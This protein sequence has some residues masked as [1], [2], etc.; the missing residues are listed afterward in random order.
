MS[1]DLLPMETLERLSRQEGVD[2]RPILVRVLTD[3]FIQKETHA[4]EDVARYEE[5]MLQL[6]DVVGVDARAAV[7]RRLADEPRAPRSV[8]D[9]LVVDDIA[10]SAPVLARSAVVPRDALLAIALDGGVAEAGA[11]AN[12]A[13]VNEDLVRIL[14]FHADD[15]VVETLAANPAARFDD[16]TLAALVERAK[17]APGLAAALLRRA[18]LPPLSLAPLYLSAGPTLRLAIRE[19]LAARP[20]RPG[21]Q[22]L[23]GDF[24]ALNAAIAKAASEPGTGHLIAETLGGALGLRPDE[25][26]RLSTEASGE[27]F[28][29]MLRA[30]G[31]DSDLVARALLVSQPQIAESVVLFFHLVEIAETTSRAVAAEL[32]AALT[33]ETRKPAQARREPLLDPSGAVE[34]AG[35]ARPAQTRRGAARPDA[36]KARG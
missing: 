8:I 19:A 24:E 5:L 16:A 2:T 14:A 10:V 3:L 30:A 31:V 29:L 13:D 15:L 18:D 11:A 7:A 6:L 20:G 36:Q 23:A 33:E 35:S 1:D 4:P 27:P 28:V 12:R 21:Q 9:R 17:R 34:R 26:A 32:V 25:A 22:R